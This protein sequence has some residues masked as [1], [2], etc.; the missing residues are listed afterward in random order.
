MFFHNTLAIA[1][2]SLVA[3]SAAQGTWPTNIV[4]TWSTKSKSTVTGPGFYDPLNDKMIEPAHT[5]ISYSFTGDGHYETAYYRAIANPVNPACPSGIMQW[6]HGSWIQN[7]NGSLSLTPIAVDGRQLMSEPCNGKTGI[8]TRY[9]QTELFKWYEY[10][11]D[12]YHN[13][14]RLNLYKFDG[15]PLPPMYLIYSPPQMLPTTTL[16]PASTASSTAAANAKR[17]LSPEVPPILLSWSSDRHDEDIV[18]RINPERLWWVGLAFT[19]VG[20]LLYFGP[21]RLG[22]TL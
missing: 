13:I 16:H 20:G 12:P 2:A 8:Y 4:G 5:G 14:P 3:F 1:G 7:A 6:Q 10:L 18:H 15:S 9:N 21:R 19:G 17:G 22:M 11:I